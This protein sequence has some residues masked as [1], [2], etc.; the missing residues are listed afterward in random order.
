MLI[1]ATLLAALAAPN[2]DTPDLITLT[3]GK[4]IECRVLYEDDATVVYTKKRKGIEIE[5]SEVASIHSVERSLRTFLESYDA[6]EDNDVDALLE[7]A[8]KC[9]A[10]ELAA[11]ARNLWIRVLTL[12]PVNDTAWT[13]LGGV[14]SKRRGWRL[15]VRGRFYNIDKLRDRVSD[16]KNAM[17]L[18]T[19][20]FLIKTDVAP[21]RALDVA[22]DIERAY[23]TFYDLLGKALRLYPFEEVPEIYMYAS[24]EDY[25]KPPVPG[26]VAW[27]APLANILHVNVPAAQS[28][29]HTAVAELTEVLLFNALK[30]TVGKTGSTPAWVQKGMAQAFGG[31]Y[32]RDPGHASWDL[33]VP[34]VAHYKTQRDADEKLSIED[35]L[36][37]AR[38]AYNDGEKSMLYTAQ[39]YT[40]VQFLVHGRDGAMRNQFAEFLKSAF[41]GK[42]AATHFKKIFDVELDE[43]D[44]EWNEYVNKIANG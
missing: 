4:E 14:Y 2:S 6:I 30:R 10:D 29:P 8:S 9:E 27:F 3:N 25:E 41:G 44:A 17:E 19:A 24:E 22:I 26:D 16:W 31:A 34:L 36:R 18:P 37:S 39:S 15:K 28:V 43:F 7:L 38:G 12:D 20:H 1:A 23:M 33:S 13:K 42:G 40:L 32:R 11:E 35:I 21:E 5:R